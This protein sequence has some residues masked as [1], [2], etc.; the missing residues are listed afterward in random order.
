MDFV[1]KI[2]LAIIV[3]IM[4]LFPNIGASGPQTIISLSYI[5]LYVLRNNF[6][7]RIPKLVRYIIICIIVSFFSIFINSIIFVERIDK[8]YFVFYVKSFIM[9]VCIYLLL[10]ESKITIKDLFKILLIILSI[11]VL[12]TWI[13]YFDILGFRDLALKMNRNFIIS[14]YV[15]YRSMGLMS[16][17]DLNGIML[18][19]TSLLFILY[20]DIFSMRKYKK[21][22]CLIFAIL[23]GLSTILASRT[24]VLSFII[25]ILFYLSFKIFIGDL[26]SIIK[27][28]LIVFFMVFFFLT[29]V[30]LL[31]HDY[32]DQFYSSF[33]LMYEA[34]DSFKATGKFTTNSFSSTLENHY[35]LPNNLRVLY[36]GNTF[37]NNLQNRFSDVGYIQTI[38]GLGIVGL[39]AMIFVHLSFLKQ[40]LNLNKYLVSDKTNS[41]NSEKKIIDNLSFF[42]YIYIIIIFIT[43]FKGPYFFSDGIF[44]IFIYIYSLLTKIS[45]SI[46]KEIIK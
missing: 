7:I 6:V 38:N 11:N 9:S 3:Y 35:F 26:K 30:N 20:S 13:Q 23:C 2:I 14:K 18:A 41:N 31:F 34:I 39:I 37:P 10:I 1:R 33:T 24:G 29:L 42:C 5:L 22:F 16:G 8:Y 45:Y 15:T 19:L 4:I 27:I 44:Y 43:C 32:Q 40:L 12:I 21:F 25:V 46:G 28:L 36:F 17:Y